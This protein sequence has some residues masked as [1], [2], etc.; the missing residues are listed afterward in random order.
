MAMPQ[1]NLIPLSLVGVMSLLAL[2][3]LLLGVAQ[4]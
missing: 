3:A 1:R 2:G 4:H